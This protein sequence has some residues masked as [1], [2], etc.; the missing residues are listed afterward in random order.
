[1]AP[2]FKPL[3]EKVLSAPA[4]TIKSMAVRCVT[5]HR[6][7]G[8]VFYVKRYLHGNTLFDPTKSIFKKPASRREWSLA[9]QLVARGVAIVPHCAHGQKWSWRGWSE[10]VLITEGLE[11]F[12]DLRT[13]QGVDPLRSQRALGEF[14]RQMHAAGVFHRDLHI[15]NLLYSPAA[16]AFCLVDVANVVLK[17]SL[18]REERIQ[19]LAK[20]NWRHPLN[21]AFYEGYNFDEAGLPATVAHQT[22]T[23]FRTNL[24]TLVQRSL[25]SGLA[26]APRRVGQLQ[27]QIRMPLTEAMERILRDPDGFLQSG[28]RLLKDGRSSTVGCR[29][30]LVLKRS[31]PRKRRNLIIDLF[32]RSRGRRAFRLARHLELVRVTS[33]IALATADRRQLGLLRC[34]YLLMEEIPGATRLRAWMGDK[35][36]V[37]RRLA[38]L[39]A[40]LHEEGFANADLK[41]SNFALDAKGNPHLLD[42]DG[43]R[44][45]KRLPDRRAVNNLARLTES[46][47]AEAV[48]GDT[49]RITR[50]DRVRFL[51]HYCQER[52]QTDWRWWW[53]KIAEQQN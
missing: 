11:G 17:T 32:R 33:P 52:K 3:L 18:T 28:A 51:Q 8:R 27:W 4:E 35:R 26:F 31:N 53:K 50:S 2:A 42:L 23:R 34:S 37:I 25:R 38:A 9:P 13:F 36:E 20:L 39:I 1:M 14:V 21:A 47:L 22:E 6:V 48:E 7:E 24:P 16:N 12:A 49:V 29:D 19:T 15:G 45:V 44:Y 41:E 5:R 30:G 46:I 43:L 10:T 40:R